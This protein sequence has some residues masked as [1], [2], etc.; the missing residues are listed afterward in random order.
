M[1]DFLFDL[2]L[3]AS[4]LVI[5]GSLCLFANVGLLLV[6]RF[7]LPR[8]RLHTE[9]SEFSGTLVQAVMVF[10]GL[11]VALI[12]VSVWQTYADVSKTL[13]Q[14]ATSIAALYRDVSCFPSP[15]VP[16]CKT[17]S[18]ITPITSSI[19]PGPSKTGAK[20]RPAGSHG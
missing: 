19:R 12:A 13:S 14:E 9:D 17:S 3:W 10:Y 5:I 11:A 7:V 6:R 16:T 20:C 15:F 1:F 4:A 2:P 18:A 8:L